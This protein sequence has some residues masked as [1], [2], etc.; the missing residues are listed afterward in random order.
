MVA[1]V[2]PSVWVEGLH[3]PAL[4]GDMALIVGVCIKPKDIPLLLLQAWH[5]RH[6]LGEV[7]WATV[8]VA[9]LPNPSPPPLALVQVRIGL[10]V[11]PSPKLPVTYPCGVG[12]AHI[13]TWVWA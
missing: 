11:C 3:I 2:F 9:A 4:F 6:P 1:F 5:C 13:P 7:V 10:V 8:V 12:A